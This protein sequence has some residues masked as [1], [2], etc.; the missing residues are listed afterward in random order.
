MSKT[1]L[2]EYKNKKIHSKD[3]DMKGNTYYYCDSN[4]TEIKKVIKTKILEFKDFYYE[5][6]VC[7]I[8][9]KK[10][11]ENNELLQPLTYTVR[12]SGRMVLRV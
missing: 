9:I 11:K 1:V 7:T 4:R 8:K 3:E 6:N 10:D 12:M 2:M 5:K